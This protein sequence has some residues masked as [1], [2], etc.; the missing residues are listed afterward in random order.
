[1]HQD[2]IL[3]LSKTGNKTVFP[4]E[5]VQHRFWKDPLSPMCGLVARVAGLWLPTGG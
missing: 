2:L 5:S 3:G 4:I 1:M